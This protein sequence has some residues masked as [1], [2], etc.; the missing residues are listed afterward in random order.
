MP[1]SELLNP[2]NFTSNPVN[3]APAIAKLIGNGA[4]MSADAAAVMT[5]SADLS[6]LSA[7]AGNLV[8]NGT[9]IAIAGGD[10]AAA[11]V[12]KINLQTGTTN[13]TASLDSDNNLVLT[14]TDA[15]TNIAIGGGSTLALLTGL[16]VSVGTTNATNLLTQGAAATGQTLTFTVGANPPLVVTF[17]AGNV[18]TLADLNTALSAPC[19]RHRRADPA[20]GD[21]TVT[22]VHHDRHDRGRRQRRRRATSASA[23]RRRCRRTIPWSART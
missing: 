3:G 8:V 13:V 20:T 21:I 18:V 19:R 10:N 17:G 16:G 23:P 12:A 7:S 22:L 9:S 5:G 4:T 1:G 11:V 14:G 6:T 15:S 2:S